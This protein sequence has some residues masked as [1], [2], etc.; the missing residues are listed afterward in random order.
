MK[1]VLL[2]KDWA[3]IVN[4]FTFKLHIVILRAIRVVKFELKN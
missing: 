2:S 4:R 1:K 3:S